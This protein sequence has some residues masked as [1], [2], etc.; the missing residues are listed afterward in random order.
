MTLITPARIQGDLDGEE[1][2][3]NED[4]DQD[5]FNVM[6]DIE[7]LNGEEWG[8][9][10]ADTNEDFS[11]DDEG[12]DVGEWGLENDDDLDA[13][14]DDEEEDAGLDLDDE[15]MVAE[16]GCDL[17]EV[18]ADFEL[19]NVE[20][21]LVRVMDPVL[22]IAKVVTP[23]DGTSEE[24]EFIL[25]SEDEAERIAPLVEA[26]IEE[27]KRLGKEAGGQAA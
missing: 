7:V 26:A 24:E 3:E 10:G 27:R 15:D 19:R 23:A 25:L 20:Y 6:D 9:V 5:D 2:D 21:S 18:I 4:A 22:L 1:D 14:D 13:E 12:Q 16:P 17:V 8:P 11:Y